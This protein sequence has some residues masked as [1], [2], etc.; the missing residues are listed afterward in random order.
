MEAPEHF[1]E[2]TYK[3]AH[4]RKDRMEDTEKR[5]REEIKDLKDQLAA[6]DKTIKEMTLTIAKAQKIADNMVDK[7]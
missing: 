4:K 2:P 1:H 5:Q 3:L 7:Q 6:K